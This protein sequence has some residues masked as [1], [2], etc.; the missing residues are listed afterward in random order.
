M[1]SIWSNVSLP[2]CICRYVYLSKKSYVGRLLPFG[3]SGS[4][5]SLSSPSIPLSLQPVLFI[6]HLFTSSSM[7]GSTY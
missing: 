5:F 4:P 7:F 1:F 6:D 3:L 2:I